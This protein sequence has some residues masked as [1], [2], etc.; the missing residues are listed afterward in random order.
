MA[1]A[2]ESIAGPLL[3]VALGCSLGLAL[4]TLTITRRRTQALIR[5]ADRLAVAAPGPAPA[6]RLWDRRLTAAFARLVGRLDA[7]RQQASHDPLT[8]LLNRQ[9]I[10][11]VLGS[12]IERAGRYGRPLSVVFVDVDHFKRV[13]DTYGHLVG[14]RVLSHVAAQIQANVRVVDR[15]GRYGG[16]EFILILPETGVDAAAM[17]ADKL[18][19]KVA[20]VPVTLEDGQVIAVTMSAGVAGSCGR[21]LELDPLIRDADAALY[22]AKGL[23]RDQVYVFRV[24]DDDAIVR[25]APIS[26]EARR[27]AIEWGTSALRAANEQLFAVLEGRS[28]VEAGSSRLIA[29]VASA[30]A[31]SVGL[32]DA[33]VER[34]RI[35]SMLHDLG[36][37]ALPEEILSKPDDLNP[38]E[39]NAVLEHPRIGQVILEQA[40][41][42]RDAAGVVLHHHEWF[43]GQ[44]YPYGLAGN[45]IPMGARIVAIADAYSAMVRGRPYRR[46]MTHEAALR[47]LHAYAGRQFDPELVAVFASLFADG[48]PDAG[49]PRAGVLPDAS[50]A[51]GPGSAGKPGRRAGRVV[52]AGVPDELDREDR[53]HGVHAHERNEPVAIPG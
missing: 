44:G 11:T 12:E 15:V 48:I 24:P 19:R 2:L 28:S 7:A 42:L 20:G 41:A 32:P 3:L 29:A 9:A 13:N 18:R 22:A 33:E 43:D 8:G 27:R 4:S 5:L 10:L 37:L 1:N 6:I 40:G 52:H 30:M 39:W 45:E 17:M 49:A 53:E 38:A 21:P 47:E 35:A 26:M 36:E 25:S 46:A 16:E 31:R 34:I 23:G 14:D 50:W 51:R